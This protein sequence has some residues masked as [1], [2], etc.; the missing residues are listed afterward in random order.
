[1]TDNNNKPTFNEWLSE[2]NYGRGKILGEIIV[3][4]LAVA[5]IVTILQGVM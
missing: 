1:M 4:A 2:N 5:L 3:G